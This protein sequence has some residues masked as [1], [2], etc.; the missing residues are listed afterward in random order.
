MRQQKYFLARRN[1]I[2]F[3]LALEDIQPRRRNS[4]TLQRCN[5]IVIDDQSPAGGVYHN[6]PGR[7]KSD[8]LGIEEVMR[9]FRLGS[10][11]AQKLTHGESSNGSAWNTV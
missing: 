3:R 6:C 1:R 4:A 11:Q 7:Q 8:G 2:Q 10:V 9:L 5:E